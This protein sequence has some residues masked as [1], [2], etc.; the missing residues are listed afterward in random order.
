MLFNSYLFILLFLP[1]VTAGFFALAR[2]KNKEFALGYL[3]LVSL[4]FY[5][6]YH[7]IYLILII[8]SILFNY[9]AGRFLARPDKSKTLL[10][11]AVTANLALLGYFK[12]ANFFVETANLVFSGSVFFKKVFLPL[13]ISFFT[14]QQIAYLVDTYRNET[15][16]ISLLRYSLF[17]SFF[18]QLIAGP[19][20]TF[21]ELVPQF[22]KENTF[23]FKRDNLILGIT[24]FTIALFKKVGIADFLGQYVDQLYAISAAGK[25]LTALAAWLSVLL[26]SLQIYFDFSAYSEMAIGLAI[27]LNIRL[28]ENFRASFRASTMKNFWQRWHMTLSR[29]LLKYLYIPLGGNRRGKSRTLL[30]VMIVLMI[31]GLWHGAALTF[32]VWGLLHALFLILEKL[33]GSYGR[34][35]ARPILWLKQAMVFLAFGLTLILFRADNFSHAW[36]HFSSLFTA[37]GESITMPPWALFF[38]LA[39]LAALLFLPSMRQLFGSEYPAL[40]IYNGEKA[41]PSLQL[42]Q[43]KPGFTWGLIVYLLMAISI[44]FLGNVQKFIYYQF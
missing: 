38:F 6:W 4:F 32:I 33:A 19:I 15:E 23:V 35:P 44:L 37:G 31:S 43:F 21:R 18:P 7:Y 26:Y 41:Q 30:N 5:A 29:F 27:M 20:V 2:L 10:I 22:K 11:I 25:P 24:I 17:V 12:Y 9:V 1:A 8:A 28:P 34:H 36:L 14:L 40:D 42:L 16:K 39:A 13:A 3:V